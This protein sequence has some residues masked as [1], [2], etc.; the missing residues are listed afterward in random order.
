LN[1]TS[2]L[3]D[4]TALMARRLRCPA[5]MRRFRAKDIATIESSARFG[6]FRLNCPMCTSQRLV[7]A[8]WNRNAVRTYTTDLDAQ[9]WVHYRHAPPIDVDDVIRISRMLSEYDGDLS[10]VLEDPLFEEKH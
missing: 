7:I 8:V 10:D 4:I 5:C 1:D 9:E 3:P 2:R 6:V